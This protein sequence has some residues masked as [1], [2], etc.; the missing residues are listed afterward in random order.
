MGNVF[1]NLNFLN[2]QGILAQK[3]Y[4]AFAIFHQ[5]SDIKNGRPSQQPIILGQLV[6]GDPSCTVIDHPKEI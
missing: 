4:D 3:T 2:A 5:F 1:L 6:S